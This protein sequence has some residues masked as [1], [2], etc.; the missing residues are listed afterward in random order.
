MSTRPFVG[1]IMEICCR[2]AFMGMLSPTITLLACA[3]FLNSAFSRRS[4]C[5]SSAFLIRISVLSSESGFSR[6]SKAP[7]FEAINALEPDVQQHQFAVFL[8]ELF[9]AFFAALGQQ[10]VITLFFEDAAQRLANIALV[11][12]YQNV[13]HRASPQPCSPPPA[14]VPLQTSRPPAG[15]LPRESSR[16]DLQ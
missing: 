8:F 7:S 9:N 6:K 11:V 13:S 2:S 12:H 5:D 15:S 14:A 16:D 4:W 10:H 3:C 1:A